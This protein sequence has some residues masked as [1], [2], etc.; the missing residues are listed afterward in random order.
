M[1]RLRAALLI[2]TSLV[3]FTAPT[4][5]A[6]DP[7]ALEEFHH[8]IKVMGRMGNHP[9]V[10]QFI[11][12]DSIQVPFELIDDGQNPTTENPLY[13]ESAQT[14]ENP[15]YESGSIAPPGSG[16]WPTAIASVSFELFD[17]GL[18][19]LHRD[20]IVH[21]DIA[22]RN[23]L[24]Q[25]NA[26]NYESAPGAFILL[27]NDGPPILRGAGVGPIRW[28]APESLRLHRPGSTDPND[29]IE[30]VP[31]ETFIDVSYVPEPASAALLGLA[32]CALLGRRGR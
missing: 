1:S 9:N 13:E 5:A 24:I 2:V 3:A 27:G 16:G 29:W 23:F 19:H 8:E 21:R 6:T 31:Q 4:A 28:M 20:N 10:V 22:A 18:P 30:I 17:P 7:K 15:L 14:A 32:G 25:T 11:G 26:G 12:T